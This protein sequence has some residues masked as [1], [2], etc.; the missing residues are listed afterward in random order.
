P[1]TLDQPRSPVGFFN[2]LSS[3]GTRYRSVKLHARGGLGEVHLAEDTELGRRVAL[4]RIQERFA[5]DAKSIQRFRREAEITAH[6]EHPG[7]VPVYG[8][9]TDTAGQPCYAMRFIEGE[10]LK[11]ACDRYHAATMTSPLNQSEHR[12]AFRQLLQS[13]IAACNAVAYAHSRGV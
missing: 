10:S 6:L 1:D 13:V 9:I 8:L 2:D 12:L 11:E 3:A 5:A 7:I 4:K